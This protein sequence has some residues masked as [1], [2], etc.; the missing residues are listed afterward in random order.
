MNPKS[1]VVTWT[2][3]S[4]KHSLKHRLDLDILIAKDIR[5]QIHGW[6]DYKLILLLDTGNPRTISFYKL[7]RI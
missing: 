7:I 6:L 3:R 4:H 1:Y 5:I 2:P